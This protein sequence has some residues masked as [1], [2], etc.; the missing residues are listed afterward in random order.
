M[1]INDTS[2]QLF[3]SFRRRYNFVF[4]R[5]PEN[6]LQFH[7]RGSVVEGGQ[8]S[9]DRDTHEREFATVMRPFLD[10]KSPIAIRAFW[11]YLKAHFADALEVEEITNLDNAIDQIFRGEI[12]VVLSGKSLDQEGIYHLLSGGTFFNDDVGASQPLGVDPS[13]VGLNMLWWLFFDLNRKTFFLA[14]E[15]NRLVH[16]IERSAP[17]PATTAPSR[18][19]YCL[20]SGGPFKAEEHIFP[21]SLADDNAVLPRGSVCDRC[22]NGVLS[23]LDEALMKFSPIALMR[24]VMGPLSKKAKFPKAD[25]GSFSIEKT[26]PRNIRMTVKGKKDPMTAPQRNPDGTISFQIQIEDQRPDF[27]MLGRA[28]MKIALGMIALDFGSDRACSNVF[29]PVR[30]FIQ[31]KAEFQNNILMRPPSSAPRPE[32]LCQVLDG[33]KATACLMVIFGVEFAVSLRE[34]PRLELDDHL[35]AAGAV[36]IP[37]YGT[38]PVLT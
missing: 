3:R 16:R 22:N 10:P 28:L 26:S 14:K 2:R 1:E 21:E 30:A 8:T 17:A 24:V 7:L 37:L 35:R 25:F 38:V 4:R 12:T 20:G 32:I 27:R 31:E 33:D 23:L 34:D 9:L 6:Q 15:L 5:F 19:I 36:A 18:C 29:D 13:K 11:I